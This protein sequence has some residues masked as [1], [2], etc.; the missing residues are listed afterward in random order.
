M[1]S[2]SYVMQSI[3]VVIQ[4]LSFARD[5]KLVLQLS[6]NLVE[7]NQVLAQLEHMYAFQQTPA[8]NQQQE[9][10]QHNISETKTS[11]SEQRGARESGTGTP[12]YDFQRPK[13]YNNNCKERR[14]TPSPRNFGREHLDWKHARNSTKVQQSQSAHLRGNSNGAPSTMEPSKPVR[15]PKTE[16][17]TKLG[18]LSEQWTTKTHHGATVLSSEISW[19]EDSFVDDATYITVLSETPTALLNRNGE[20]MSPSHSEIGPE[21]SISQVCEQ[22]S[23]TVHRKRAFKLSRWSTAFQ[24]LQAEECMGRR[25]VGHQESVATTYLNTVKE[26]L[27]QLST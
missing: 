25:A 14:Q 6:N 23:S 15:P 7:L 22:S 24:N 17:W 4:Q 3:N 18:I 13:A 12:G 20:Q 26:H 9:Q 16:D 2:I 10:V 27:V 5:G 8:R 1:E 21:D 11:N 19:D